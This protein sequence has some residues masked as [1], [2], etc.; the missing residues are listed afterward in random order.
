MAIDA[1]SYAELVQ[2]LGDVMD[3]LSSPIICE[4]AL[5]ALEALI[6]VPRPDQ[7]ALEAFFGRV[8][9][10]FK[11]WSG[12]ID[13]L[14]KSLFARFVDEFG[15]PGVRVEDIGEETASEVDPLFDALKG[16]TLALYS[17][18]ERALKRAAGAL[19][20]VYPDT[21]ISVFHDRVGGSP[22]L[23][24]ATQ[25]ADIFVIAP[26]S[27]KH[28]AT[29]YI[30]QHRP[31]ELLTLYARGQGSVGLLAVVRENA[32]RIQNAVVGHRA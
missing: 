14:Q 21:N 9:G 20:R 11:R 32:G 2:G 29:V 4:L 13:P 7:P 28:A 1:S 23:R 17:L 3:R 15:V 12:R 25:K 16:T 27:A 19:K 26:A 24:S 6:N 30:E 18:N 31:R 10:L 8:L 5:D 22:A